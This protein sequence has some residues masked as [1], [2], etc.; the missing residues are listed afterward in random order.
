MYVAAFRY[1]PGSYDEEFHELN[2]AVEVAAEQTDGYLGRRSWESA[3]GEEVLVNYRWASLDAL[4][5]FAAHGDHLE[6]KQRWEEWYEGY[7]VTVMEV[8]ERYGSD[9]DG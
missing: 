5:A 6:A 7:E 3:D 9:T 4:A 8:V 2:A 1:R